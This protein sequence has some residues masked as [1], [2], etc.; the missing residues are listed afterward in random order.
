MRL[1]TVAALASALLAGA[2]HAN[3]AEIRKAVEAMFP[4][5]K[6]SAVHPTPMPGVF[7]VIANDEIIYADAQG[8]FLMHGQLLD[9]QSRL[10]LT[11][12]RKKK[13]SAIDF[14]TLPLH[15]ATKIVRGNGARVF[16]SFEDPN[17]GYC[18]RLHI[19]LK[20]LSDYTQYVF[21]VP[22]LGEESRQRS[23]E[24]W[25]TKNRAQAVTDWMTSNAAPPERAACAKTPSAELSALAR[26]LRVNATPTLFL[27][28]G[29]RVPGY[30]APE[31]LEAA[32]GRSQRLE[33]DSARRGSVPVSKVNTPA[34]GS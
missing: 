6:V 8:K 34:E 31:Q 5:A 3:E 1:R 27:R 9:V 29:T 15:L 11:D 33:P 24:L 7:E 22:I 21:L 16:A 23:D 4:S 14:D 28:D 19:G 10:N 17:C 2:A 13:L 20:Q 30:L 12:E 26:K 25:C 32:L 18:K